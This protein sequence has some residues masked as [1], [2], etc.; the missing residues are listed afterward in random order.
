MI[1]EFDVFSGR[2]NPTW[3]LSE[4][5]V[6]ELLAAFKDL[7]LANKPCQETGIGYRG[8]VILNPRR[9]GGLAPRIRVCGGIIAMTGDDEQLYQDVHGLEN[10]LLLQA[11]QRGYVTI[12]N[13]VLEG[14]FGTESDR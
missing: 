2:P 4:E 14:K 8:F 13:N 5:E 3:S 6:V 1:I 7:P 10:R 12:V 9:E 11:S